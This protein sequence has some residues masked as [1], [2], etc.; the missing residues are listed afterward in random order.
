MATRLNFTKAAIEA[1][2]LPE[3]GKR[4]WAYDTKVRGLA[5]QVTGTGAK[6]FY[7]VRKVEGKTEFYRLGAYP[8]LT[9]E[10]VRKQAQAVNG[11]IAKGINPAEARREKRRE[12]TLAELI[13]DYMEHHAKLHKRSWRTDELRFKYLSPWVKRKLSS[14]KRTEVK[15]LHARIGETH[16]RYAANRLLALLRH[17]FNYAIRERSIPLAENPALGV[18]AFKEEKRERW[19]AAEELPAFFQAVAEETNPDI[20]DF[21][22][23]SLLTG[24]R[25]GNVLSMCWEEVDLA[26]AVWAIPGVKFKTGKPLVI[27]LAPQALDLLQGRKATYGN[28]GQGWTQSGYVFPSHGSTGH[29]VEPKAGWARI[30]KRAGIENLRLHDLRHTLASWQV[31]LGVSLAITGR[32]LGHNSTATT[33]RYAH[34][35]VDPVRDA[36]NKAVS[37]MLEAGGL[38]EKAEV[39]N[40]KGDRA[41]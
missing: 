31:S 33:A 21:V 10:Q 12:W 20:R 2:P 11:E 5:L 29:M 19:L 3:A 1:L 16:G 13:S 32:A 15:T 9:V 7:V 35:G 36:M 6:S 4:L 27:P 30:L 23:L 37:A 25:K 8:D 26:R 24:A 22:L 14:I 41:A 39:I 34:L 28:A 40:I 18:K 17:M 38:K